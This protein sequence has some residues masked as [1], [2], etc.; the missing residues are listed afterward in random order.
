[1]V[2][3]TQQRFPDRHESVTNLEDFNPIIL[4]KWIITWPAT[5][6]TFHS[7]QR[8]L[9]ENSLSPRKCEESCFLLHSV[10]CT[11]SSTASGELQLNTVFHISSSYAST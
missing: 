5:F 7:L 4:K 6:F 9:N 3:E 8:H 1:M 11:C 10:Y 2:N